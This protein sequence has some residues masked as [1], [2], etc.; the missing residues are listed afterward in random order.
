MGKASAD[1]PRVCIDRSELKAAATEDSLVRFEHLSVAY[2]RPV[3]I[4][5]KAIRIFHTE[6]TASHHTETGAYLI[7]KFCL[8]LI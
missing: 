3:F 4:H 7:A 8:N 1:T 6:F 5:V 2:F